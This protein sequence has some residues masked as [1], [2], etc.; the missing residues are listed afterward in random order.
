M[1]DGRAKAMILAIPVHT[2]PGEHS[3][4]PFIFGG[5]VLV[6]LLLLSLWLAWSNRKERR[7]PVAVQEQRVKEAFTKPR[8]GPREEPVGIDLSRTSL[9]HDRIKEIAADCGYDF[10]QHVKHRNTNALRF[11]RKGAG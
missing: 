3:L 9:S 4:T 11:V 8:W 6:L 1:A 7:A 10:S 5:V 2:A